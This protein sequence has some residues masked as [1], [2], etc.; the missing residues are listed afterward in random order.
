MKPLWSDDNDLEFSL[1]SANSDGCIANLYE[2]IQCM[3][4]DSQDQQEEINALKAQLIAS[5]NES[6]THL[7][8]SERT[9]VENDALKAQVNSF[10]ELQAK[11]YG[12]GMRTHMALIKLVAKVKS[13]T[14]QQGDSNGK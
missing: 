2:D 12:D 7:A 6:N 4:E 10:I 9:C 11:Y 14:Y 5:S 1:G 13:E 8:I 3:H